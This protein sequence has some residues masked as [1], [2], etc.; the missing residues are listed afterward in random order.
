MILGPFW[1]PCAKTGVVRNAKRKS[2]TLTNR[3]R[4][5][6]FRT[7]D[8]NSFSDERRGPDNKKYSARGK[9]SPSRMAFAH[10]GDSGSSKSRTRDRS[11]LLTVQGPG[12]TESTCT[13]L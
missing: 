4:H 13:R 8:G 12:A 5:L 7:M 3:A 9:R 11:Q 6:R 10:R 1:T 2:R